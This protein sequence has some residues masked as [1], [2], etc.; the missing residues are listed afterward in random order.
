MFVKWRC[1]QDHLQLLDL[2]VE[3][4]SVLMPLLWTEKSY[5]NHFADPL[6]STSVVHNPPGNMHSKI[7]MRF[8]FI[9]DLTSI[10]IG[11]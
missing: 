4:A 2:G 9:K 7:L 3:E 6:N 5:N 8:A 1:K 10:C 11:S